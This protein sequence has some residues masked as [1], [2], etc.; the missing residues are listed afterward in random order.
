MASFSSNAPVQAGATDRRAATPDAAGAARARNLGNQARLRRLA[1]PSG[2]D[3]GK[4]GGDA[5]RAGLV[6]GDQNDPLEHEADRVADQVMRASAPVAPLTSIEP[7]LH[8]KCSAC[9]DEEKS[10]VR[11]KTADAAPAQAGQPAPAPVRDVLASPGHPL[12]TSLRD[13]FE[14]RF[15]ADFGAVRMHT[16]SQAGASARAVGALAY[17]VDN[18]VVVDPDHYRPHSDSGRRLL[19]HELTHTLQQGDG[20]AMAKLRRADDDGALP[21][22]APEALE[23]GGEIEDSEEGEEDE[24][25]DGDTEDGDTPV[26]GIDET[27]DFDLGSFPG[28]GNSPAPDDPVAPEAQPLATA[29]RAVATADPAPQTSDEAEPEGRNPGKKPSGKISHIDVNQTTQRMVLTFTNGVQSEEY[30]VSTGRGKCGTK[31][32]DPCDSQNNINCTPN[33]TKRLI[34]GRGT[35]KQKN[36]HGDKIWWFVGLDTPGRT[37]IGI[38]NSQKAD[39]IPRSHGCIRTGKEGTA[40]DKLA[41]MINKQVMVKK[42]TV[43][44]TGKAKTSPYPCK[45]GKGKKKGGKGKK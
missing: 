45:K 4:H 12:D 36:S 39:G 23:E 24:E 32:A 20:A 8:R 35:G 18:H 7:R 2:R 34:T 13:F 16:D 11:A 25:E 33:I 3:G 28:L 29:N 17:A 44:I 9:E 40:G 15:G 1:A 27:P 37:G 41:E 30:V 42:T 43:T 22:E 10:S 31:P 19:A 21:A 26:D 38:H 14:P 5:A 6:I